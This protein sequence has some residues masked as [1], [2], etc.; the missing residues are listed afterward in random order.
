MAPPSP[1]GDIPS[2]PHPP[3][4]PPRARTPH[5]PARSSARLPPRGAE[6]A[7]VYQNAL[8]RAR[9][10]PRPP[11][12]RTRRRFYGARAPRGTR[13]AKRDRSAKPRG[14]GGGGRTRPAG[15]STCGRVLSRGVNIHQII[16]FESTSASRPRFA[17]A[18][19]W[20]QKVSRGS[21]VCIVVSGVFAVARGEDE[22]HAFWGGEGAGHR[23]PGR[24]EVHALR[25][26]VFAPVRAR[27]RRSS[28][29]ERGAWVC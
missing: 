3:T 13:D 7:P 2:P 5:P 20:I 6:N 24:R 15:G 25:W 14:R 22:T 1:R 10:R 11:S 26:R 18:P 8:A 28:E 9:A 17:C 23:R 4:H 16:H 12:K 19:T 29:R 27:T 21:H